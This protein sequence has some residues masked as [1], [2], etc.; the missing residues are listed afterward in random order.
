MNSLVIFTDSLHMQIT[1]AAFIFFLF[2]G[3]YFVGARRSEADGSSTACLIAGLAIDF[4]AAWFGNNIE[5]LSIGSSLNFLMA[6][7]LMIKLLSLI[8]LFLAAYD[9]LIGKFP[10]GLAV[11]VSAVAGAIIIIYFSVI[12]PNG[13][14]VNILYG[15]LPAIGFACL[16][17]AYFT[18]CFRRHN[19]GA[20]VATGVTLFITV[21]A[22]MS[23][24]SEGGLNEKIWY[25]GAVGFFGM[26]T[27]LLLMMIDARDSGLDKAGQKLNKYDQRIKEIMK[28]SPFP[29]MI[30]RLSDD[31]VLLA[32][33]NFLKVFGVAEKDIASCRFRD[34]FVDAE[35]RR[36]LN[37]R[38]EKEHLVK[39]FEI[40]VKPQ[41][42][43]T[44]FWLS[45][46]ANIIDYDYDI[47]IYAAFQDITDRK[48]REDMLQMQATRD[49]LTSLF[50]RRYFKEEV[51][52]R[53]A[54]QGSEPFSVFMIDADHFK[55]V[56]D[57]YG[58]HIGDK[59]LIALS[60]AAQQAVPDNA[61]VARYGGEEFV[62]YL[63][64]SSAVQAKEIAEQLRE[65][66]AGIVVDADAGAQVRF[67]VS[68]GIASSA[69]S[70][71]I[72]ELVKM[73]DEALYKAKE[74]G[75]NR[76]EIYQKPAE[77]GA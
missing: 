57:T 56:N 28:L 23:V 22:A 17:A 41:K 74:S 45:T 37:A 30:S 24:Q 16:T 39:D 72:G 20:L 55:N 34:F 43:G 70:Q 64:Q 59:V 75:R 35:N 15:L 33:D 53:I 48:K 69:E 42:D 58:H 13:A 51:S 9:I 3:F 4:V 54:A 19:I 31:S 12:A 61:V 50:N 73:A 62:V 71:D 44:P 1:L 11:I 36:L 67:T 38:L 6:C 60:A 26:G 76:C 25:V 27:A 32:N 68:I 2:C 66:I 49:S 65:A 46:S 10:S 18:R 29:I 7:N 47:A 8:L 52:R 40:F 14:M 21:M 77:G 5:S 63:P